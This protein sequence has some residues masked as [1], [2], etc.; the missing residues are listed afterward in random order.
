MILGK[1]NMANLCDKSECTGCAACVAV[2]PRNA[3]SF[4]KDKFG[5]SYP[6]INDSLCINCKMCEKKCPSLVK[7]N[8]NYPIKAIA[9]HVLDER[10]RLKS[11][12]GGFATLL[13]KHFIESG[14]VVYGC[15]F[16]NPMCVKHIRCTTVGDLLKLRGSKYVQSSL[17]EIYAPLQQDLIQNT[18][19]LFIG[20]PCQVAGIKSKFSKYNNLFIVDLVCHGVP[21]LQILHDSLPKRLHLTHEHKFSFRDNISYRIS[22]QKDNRLV[23]ERPL[24]KDI[25]YKGF[26]NGLIFRTSC[27]RCNYAKHERISDLTIGDFWG[28]ESE[29]ITDTEKGVSL[30]LV[31]TKNG[32]LLLGELG[33]KLF[34]ETRSVQEAFKKNAQLNHPYGENIRSRLF[35]K[36]YPLFGYKCAIWLSVPDKMIGSRIK[37]K[38]HKE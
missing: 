23:Y 10:E 34:S 28:L 32:E 12:S 33:D 37:N 11:S 2:C 5:F 3:I 14:G 35:R 25:F 7:Q 15:S 27:Y 22:I 13:A 17:N 1:N 20:T 9:C 21:S 26:F 18:K 24:Y 38:L 4:V 8:S 16:E 19:V 36:I 30:V 6:V 29:K 31:N